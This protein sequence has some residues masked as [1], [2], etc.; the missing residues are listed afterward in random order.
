[1]IRAMLLLS[2]L[3]LFVFVVDF[4]PMVH[5]TSVCSRHFSDAASADGKEVLPDAPLKV[6]ATML[7]KLAKKAGEARQTSLELEMLNASETLVKQMASAATALESQY[8]S[9]A[10]VVAQKHTSIDAYRPYLDAAEQII[11][12][13]QARKQYADALVGVSKRQA[14]AASAASSTVAASAASHL[15]L[16]G[17]AAQPDEP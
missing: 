11:T 15:A 3:N 8:K 2:S 13:Y 6:A 7:T 9:L 17:A 1:M 14:A 12:Y 16:A 4:N 5:G 10:P